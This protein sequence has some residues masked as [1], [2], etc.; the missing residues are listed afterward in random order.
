MWYGPDKSMGA[1]LGLFQHGLVFQP[2]DDEKDIYR[3]VMIT[4]IPQINMANVLKP[5]CGGPLYSVHLLRTA[6]LTGSH[7]AIITFLYEDDAREFVKSTS[8]KN[9]VYLE[10]RANASLIRT[11]TFPIPKNLKDL[12]FKQGHTR[13]LSISQLSEQYSSG[14]LFNA[15]LAWNNRFAN[16]LEGIQEIGSGAFHVRFHSIRAAGLAFFALKKHADFKYCVIK[17][18]PDPCDRP[19][20]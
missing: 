17:F 9:I 6:H 15:L 18:V 7:S 3:A 16:L 20:I 19:A 4:G 11:P 10:N 13:C 14:D 8:I 12:I 5:V 2:N 1:D